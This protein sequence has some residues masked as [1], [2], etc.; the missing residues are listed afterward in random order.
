MVVKWNA[1]NEAPRLA[2]QYG[3]L[4][5]IDGKRV[6]VLMRD[7][8]ARTFTASVKDVATLRSLLGKTIAFH[9]H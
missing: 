3:T 2:V 7:G 8:T 4:T 9:V 1:A 6:T 5:A